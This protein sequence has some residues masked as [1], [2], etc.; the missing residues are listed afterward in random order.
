MTA[1]IAAPVRSGAACPGH[2]RLPLRAGQ[3]AVPVADP[4]A[5]RRRLGRARG[6][7][8]RGQPADH[9]ADR[10]GLRPLDARHRL[11]RIAGG[12][13]LRLQLGAAAA[14]LAGRRRRL[15][16][17]GPARH[18]AAPARRRPLTA[19]DL[20]GQGAGQ[21]HGHRAAVVGL[22]V[23]RHRRGP[24][25][26]KP[27]AGRPGR[28]SIAPADAAGKVRARLAVRAGADAGVRRGRPARL[29]GA[30]PLPDGAADAGAARAGAGRRPAAAAAGR[31]PCRPAELRLHRLAWSVH[32]ARRRPGPCSSASSS[33]SSGRSSRPGWRTGCSC[34]AT[35]PTSADGVVPAGRSQSACC[36]W[37]RC[38]P[39]PSAWSPLSVPG[40]GLGDRP[41]QAAALA[42]DGVRPPLPCCRPAAAPAGRHRGAAAGLARPAT[43]AVAWSTTAGRATTGAAS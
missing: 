13:R 30:R 18:L 6:A 34:G 19:A 14:D 28:A 43:R 21:P 12:A 16:R 40:V 39:S 10:H 27:A 29:G 42:R 9:A 36:R 35:S 37:S 25:R 2:P 31:R 23:L 8:G 5:A 1:T 7:G 3:A 17:R 20:R 24:R 4:A 33:A 38:S 11:G 22:A 32:R 15:R 26:R 41:G